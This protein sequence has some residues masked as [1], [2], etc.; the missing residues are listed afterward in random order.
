MKCRISNVVLAGI[1]FFALMAEAD[2]CGGPRWKELGFGICIN[3]KGGSEGTGLS[4][5]RLSTRGG[6]VEAGEIVGW[7]S[8]NVNYFVFL[9]NDTIFEDFPDSSEGVAEFCENVYAPQLSKEIEIEFLA[10]TDRAIR[11][12][13]STRLCDESAIAFA[14]VEE[15]ILGERYNTLLVFAST[16]NEVLVLNFP[17]TLRE[18]GAMSAEEIGDD[19]VLLNRIVENGGKLS[20]AEP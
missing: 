4:V 20:V 19:L 11:A 13:V 3:V 5:K 1:V 12:N 18:G 7:K 8:D 15:R 14:K 9:K 10:A 16:D 17:R 2:L 6:V